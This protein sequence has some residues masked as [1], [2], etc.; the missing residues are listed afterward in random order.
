MPEL[1][2]VETI[3]RC[4]EPHLV[5]IRIQRTLVRN[6]N[7]RWPVPTDLADR[8]R[9]HTVR[10]LE[11]RGKYLLMRFDTGTAIFHLGMSG[12]LLIRSAG[13]PPEKH[14]HLQIFLETGK[15]L[16]L[17]DPRRFGCVLWTE[18]DPLTH[19]LLARLGPEPFD[20]SF[21]GGYLYR[22]SHGRKAPVKNFI[23]DG[24]VVTGVGNIYANEA[25]FEAA[26]D[27]RRATGRISQKRYRRLAAAIRSVL[28]GAIRQGGTTLR[29]YCDAAGNPGYFQL[30]LNV[31]GR[32]GKPCPNCRKPLT[33]LRLGR[34]A[35]TLCVSCQ[36]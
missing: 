31:Y 34:R 20:E 28:Q 30:Q 13:L 9:N 33:T 11:R 6:P 10:C 32:G 12:R 18:N 23:M 19:P 4:L 26:I 25:L 8:L 22:L 27:P 29:D 21:S 16:R 35:T 2:E 15:V 1:P 36:R 24:R 7:L 14:D 3:R 5:G 17:N